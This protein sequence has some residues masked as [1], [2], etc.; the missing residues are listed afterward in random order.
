MLG[1]INGKSGTLRHMASF[2]KISVSNIPAGGDDMK[3]IFTADKRITGEF[4]ADLLAETPVI[5]TDESEGNTVTIH[6]SN[7]TP[8]GNGAFY[9]PAPLGTYGN[10]EVEIFDGEISVTI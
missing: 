9:I 7:M 4:T 2:F 8:G 5:V 3:L 1:R 6:F 10:I